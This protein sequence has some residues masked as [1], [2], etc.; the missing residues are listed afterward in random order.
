MGMG[1]QNQQKNQKNPLNY[2]IVKC[3]NFEKD[4]TCKCGSHCTFAHGDADLRSKADNYTNLQ[5]NV[6]MMDPNM[7]YNYQMMQQMG[8]MPPNFD[9]NQMAMAGNFDPNQ[10]MMNMNPQMGMDM[11]M[12]QGQTQQ[13]NNS[14]AK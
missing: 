3:K 5:P 12:P 8:M 11:M 2:K 6:N 1:D 9:V 7:M 14:E 10:M 4:G 13:G